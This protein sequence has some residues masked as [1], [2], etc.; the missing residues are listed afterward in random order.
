VQWRPRLAS[1]TLTSQSDEFVAG[2]LGQVTV[3]VGVDCATSLVEISDIAPPCLVSPSATTSVGSFTAGTWRIGSLGAGDTATLTLRGE[4]EGSGDCSIEARAS[5]SVPTQREVATTTIG[6]PIVAEEPGEPTESGEP[7]SVVCPTDPHGFVDVASDSFA[8]MPVRCL[9]GLEITTG[10]GPDTYSPQQ[11][12]TR[13]QMAAFVARTWMALGETCST[14]AHGFADIASDSFA[15]MPVRCIKD[16]NITQGTSD[17]T[18]SPGDPVTREQMAAFVARTW[19]SLGNSCPSTP[20]RFSDV[21]STSFADADIACIKALDITT[22]TGPGTYSP[23]DP[24]TREQM[25]AFIARLIG[26][27]ASP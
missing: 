19:R 5:M 27:H 7:A 14:T 13:D 9:K 12:V 15:E 21:P 25:A 8:E 23:N 2:E 24:V 3:T 22:G 6:G 10:T 1:I 16:L 18:Y 17:T 20:H 4:V 11:V 26:A